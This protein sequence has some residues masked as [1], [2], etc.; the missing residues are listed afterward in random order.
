MRRTVVLRADDQ[1]RVQDA[2]EAIGIHGLGQVVGRADLDALLAIALHRLGRE[3][4]DRQ[5]AERRVGADAADGAVNH[6]PFIIGAY[7]AT[8]V[9]TIALVAIS[10]WSM[11]KAERQVDE[12]RREP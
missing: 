1:A 11:R 4:D 2:R 6:L 10:Y 5:R 7:V 9:G 8:F 3:R 12:L